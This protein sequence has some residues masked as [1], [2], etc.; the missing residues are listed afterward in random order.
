MSDERGL[1]PKPPNQWARAME[2]AKA[3]AARAE[4]LRER[5]DCLAEVLVGTEPQEAKTTAESPRPAMFLND[6]AAIFDRTQVT[7]GEIEHV[8][9]RME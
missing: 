5:L 4:T 2:Q 8:I 9:S 7:L 3:I 6:L 1:A